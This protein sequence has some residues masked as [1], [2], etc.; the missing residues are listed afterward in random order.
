M[1]RVKHKNILMTGGTGF[2]GQILA[3]EFLRQGHRLVVLT[4]DPVRA[5]RCFHYSMYPVELVER[6]S[7]MPL[8]RHFDIVI[9]LSGV[10]IAERR[11][12]V[13][14]KKRL[15]TSRVG[16]TEELVQWMNKARRKPSLLLSA[17]AVGYYGD[18]KDCILNEQCSGKP[19]FTHE[20]CERWE[21]AALQANTL[22]VRVCLLRLGAVLGP[23]DSGILGKL[24]SV[25]RWGLG[26][27]LGSGK[28][29][30][31]WIHV[32]DV[33]GLVNFF[34]ENTQLSGPFNCVAPNPVQQKE[35]AS[36]LAKAEH[37]P[38]FMKVPAVLLKLMLGEQACLLLDSI[39]AVPEKALKA[40]YCFRYADLSL[41]LAHSS[42]TLL[43]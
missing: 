11:W 39:R 13:Q 17:S 31:P 4:R 20:L 24:K 8:D 21:Q 37:R 10:G 34:S 16:I 41:A 3:E 2:I 25:Y 9:N 43:Q 18:N 29:W 23:G 42:D 27:A 32:Q 35:F 33:L 22:D 26:G 1:E 36:M 7:Q 28:Q 30:L 6:C 38:A 12:T 15:L 19:G 5:K 40:G 14:Q